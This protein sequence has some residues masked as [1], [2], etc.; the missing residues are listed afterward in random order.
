MIFGWITALSV[1]AG[2]VSCICFGDFSNLGFLW[3]MVLGFGA[4]FVGL[5]LLAF[6]FLMI[7][8]ALVD[9]TKPQEQD[10]KFYRSIMYPYIEALM[11]LMLVDLET[12]GLE[13]TPKEG[14]F[15]LVCNHLQL[16]DPGILLHCF[17]G[18][19]LAFI[20]KQE[21]MEL[22]VI[23]K[24]MHKILCQML[25]RDNDR[26]ALKVILK[27]IQLIKEDKVSVG[28]FPEGYTSKDGRLQ[29]FRSGVFKIAQKANVPIV[30]CTIRGTRDLFH[31]VKRLKKT[32][33]TLHLADVIP[34]EALKGKTA[35][36]ISDMVRKAMAEDLGPGLVAE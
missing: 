11:Q 21:N 15:L 8:C 19:Q 20:S 29:H 36:E 22:P 16:A 3:W 14:R 10:S 32:K 5:S 33:V 24:F 4:G 7:A 17:R 26:Q 12:E 30:V 6:I 31:N 2:A 18:S 35:V 25:D 9:T 34:A 13:K 23:N 28:V 27:C 1:V